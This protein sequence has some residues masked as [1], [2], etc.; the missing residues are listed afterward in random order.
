MITQELKGK[1]SGGLRFRD[2]CCLHPPLP[3]TPGTPTCPPSIREG[4]GSRTEKERQGGGGSWRQGKREG[5][6]KKKSLL[7]HKLVNAVALSTFSS[8]ENFR[9]LHINLI[10]CVSPSPRP[11][12]ASLSFSPPFIKSS[13]CFPLQSACAED[14]PEPHS[15]SLSLSVSRTR[16]HTSTRA[17]PLP[18]PSV[19]P[20]PMNFHRLRA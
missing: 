19:K 18:S 14:S 16:A 13:I 6:E 15:L 5:K 10:S 17:I 4:G 20:W 7:T 9:H 2:I 8:N 1:I 12:P 11:P 3:A